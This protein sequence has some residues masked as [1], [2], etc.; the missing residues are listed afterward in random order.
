MMRSF[1][2]RP[3]CFVSDEPFYGAFL[4]ETGADHPMA[5]EVIA[6][7]ETD[8]RKVAEALAGDPPDGSPVWYQ[9]HMAH[10]MVGPIAP[11][12]LE[13]L[14]HAFLIRDPHLMAASYA[15]KRETVTSA[16]LGLRLQREFF[17]RECQRLGHAPPVIDS[18]YVLAEPSGVLSQL[19][20]AL[21]ISW[22]PAMLSWPAGRHPQDGIWASHWYGHVEASTGFESP[23]FTDP[24]PLAPALQAVADACMDDYLHL[25]RFAL[26]NA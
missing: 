11:D 9:K 20:W 16:D 4:K 26:R 21:G 13:G 12:D 8:W 24:L 10:H 6:S 15:R 22:D 17:D 2:S 1:S 5:E 14:T 19:C 23:D 25:S 18:A 3:D 7:M